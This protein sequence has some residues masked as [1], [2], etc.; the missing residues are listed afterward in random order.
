MERQVKLLNRAGLH[1]RSAAL[2]VEEA[3]KYESD[4]KLVDG[5][6]T[7]NAKSILSIISFG[8]EEGA[9]FKIVAEGGDA[10]KA[11]DGLERLMND[12]KFV[13]E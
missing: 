8:A 13:E 12:K 11:L 9:I 10:E 3:N 6:R 1:A 7:A 4:I 5:E 2:F